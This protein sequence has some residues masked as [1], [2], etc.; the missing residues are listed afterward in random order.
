MHASPNEILTFDVYPNA[1]T[2]EE[3]I[4]TVSN[5]TSY[6]EKIELDESHDGTDISV[7][8]VGG[9]MKSLYQQVAKSM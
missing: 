2:S 3:T 7:E 6:D 1:D 8:F 5:P 4:C 9:I